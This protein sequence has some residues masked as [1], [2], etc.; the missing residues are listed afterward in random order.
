MRGQ[1]PP[2]LCRGRSGAIALTGGVSPLTPLW[3]K[4]VVEYLVALEAQQSRR[5]DLLS[6]SQLQRLGYVVL[7]HLV[8][9][10]IEAEAR[11]QGAIEDRVHLVDLLHVEQGILDSAG[12][13]DRCR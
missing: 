4:A 5:L 3:R 2:V 9:E 10:A 1:T 13:Q 12:V 7:L 6:L 11:A 8:H